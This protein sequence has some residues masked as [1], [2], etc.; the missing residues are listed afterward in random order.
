M[1]AK[2]SSSV[3]DKLLDELYKHVEKQIGELKHKRGYDNSGIDDNTG[4]DLGNMLQSASQDVLATGISDGTELVVAA[5]RRHDGS[6]L[7]ESSSAQPSAHVPTKKLLETTSRTRSHR[8]S[9]F[10]VNTPR[11]D[12]IILKGRWMVKWFRNSWY[13]IVTN[14]KMGGWHSGECL[15]IIYLIPI[16]IAK[17]IVTMS[18]YWVYNRFYKIR[19]GENMASQNGLTTKCHRISNHWPRVIK[20]WRIPGNSHWTCSKK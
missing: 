19:F 15:H 1:D 18:F 16:Y 10:P 6:S 7:S 9:A 20:Q 4:L 8:N 12:V 17:F 5:R 11:S 2:V 3:P 13:W 14:F